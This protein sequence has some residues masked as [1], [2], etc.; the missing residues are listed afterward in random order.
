MSESGFF[1]SSGVRYPGTCLP[2]CWSHVPAA[3]LVTPVLNPGM[4]LPPEAALATHGR[5]VT[6]VLGGEGASLEA[7]AGITV[8]SVGAE[9]TPKQDTA[10][11]SLCP[12]TGSCLLVSQILDPQDLLLLTPPSSDHL[13]L[14]P[15]FALKLEGS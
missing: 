1:P 5:A 6:L 15:I 11:R 8:V 10:V 13:S 9:G 7:A 12:P 14:L 4:N 2:G 3:S